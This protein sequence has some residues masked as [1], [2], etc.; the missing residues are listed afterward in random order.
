MKET[1]GGESGRDEMRNRKRR[2]DLL[3]LD[4]R[5][6][7]FFF[8]FLFPFSKKKE[9]G[10]G[11]GEGE[12]AQLKMRLCQ[13]DTETIECMKCILDVFLFIHTCMR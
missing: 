7:F 2:E 4:K 12:G 8:F 5:K 11:G 6:A 13:R 1:G 10:E 3:L 9:G